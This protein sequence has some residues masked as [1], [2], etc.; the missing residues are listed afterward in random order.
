[1]KLAG[2]RRESQA[3]TLSDEINEIDDII[4]EQGSAIGEC[5]LATAKIRSTVRASGS[6]TRSLAN[7]CTF[8]SDD[9]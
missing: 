3:R 1:M 2:P 7:R 6:R 9:A 5:F 4:D 8:Y